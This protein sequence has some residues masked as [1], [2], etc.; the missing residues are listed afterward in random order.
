[1]FKSHLLLSIGAREVNVAELKRNVVH[2]KKKRWRGWPF[3]LVRRKLSIMR[4]QRKKG[5]SQD[6][7]IIF[8]LFILHHK[9][10]ETNN[11]FFFIFHCLLSNR[12]LTFVDIKNISYTTVSVH[13]AP[14]CNLPPVELQEAKPSSSSS[15]AS[16]DYELSETCRLL[17][18][19]TGNPS[20]NIIPIKRYYLRVLINNNLSFSFSLF[21]RYPHLSLLV[22]GLLTTSSLVR[23]PLPQEFYSR[24]RL[25]PS[26]PPFT[27]SHYLSFALPRS[28]QPFSPLSNALSPTGLILVLCRTEREN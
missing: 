19:W 13:R 22:H 2:K 27:A 17:S 25:T 7:F 16:L 28:Y 23:E 3:F 6:I 4:W 24:L 10:I 15:T 20:H 5:G 8:Y 11:I 9:R 21:L 14:H 1:M 12:I 26:A 18:F